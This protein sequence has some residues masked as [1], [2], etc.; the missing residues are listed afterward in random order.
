MYNSLNPVF[1]GDNKGVFS[2]QISYGKL[3]KAGGLNIEVI[4]WDRIRKDDL[5]GLANIEPSQLLNFV[6]SSKPSSIQLQVPLGRKETEAGFIDLD[7]QNAESSEDCGIGSKDPSEA[8]TQDP[9]SMS[10]EF[11]RD[12]AE[13]SEATAEPTLND[14]IHFSFKIL[15]CRNLCKE[16]AYDKMKKAGGLDIA[17]IDWDAVGSSDTIGLANIPPS[18]VLAMAESGKPD[19]IRLRVPHGRREKTAEYIVLTIKN[20]VEESDD[21]W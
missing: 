16:F 11:S 3:K 15:S 4:D 13:V 14:M 19:S 20:V 10:R 1:S 12:P 5:I 21:D 7:I 17:V 8:F 2:A 9:V 18:R 6:K